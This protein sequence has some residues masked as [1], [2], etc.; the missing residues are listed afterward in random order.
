LEKNEEKSN[1]HKIMDEVS[2]AFDIASE[3]GLEVEVFAFALSEL[4]KGD[5][6]KITKALDYGLGEWIK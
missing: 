6:D 5:L 2:E 4:A 1:T 3:Y